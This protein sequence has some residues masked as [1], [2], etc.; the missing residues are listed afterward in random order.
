[1]P[2]R[3]ARWPSP[4][5]FDYIVIGAGT[6]GCVVAAR[7]SQ[8]GRHRVLLLEAGDRDANFWIRVP[9]GSS[10]LKT[11]PRLVWTYKSEPEAELN[12]RRVTYQAGH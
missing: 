10:R 6:A 1:M 9:L 12:G 7:L 4:P 2:Q 3:A 8:S 5:A 11:N